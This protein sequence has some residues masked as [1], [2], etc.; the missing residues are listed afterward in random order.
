MVDGLIYM[1]YDA[2]GNESKPFISIECKNF[3]AV[4][5][6]SELKKVFKRIKG[7]IQCALVF[8]SS[9]KE[10][11]F[12]RTSLGNL[13]KE[14]F[15]QDHQADSVSVMEWDSKI[16]ADPKLLKVG[17]EIFKAETKTSLLVV[18]ISVGFVDAACIERKNER[19]TPS[20]A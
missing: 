17:G 18:I 10:N 7:G 16:E 6:T 4:V 3:A 5:D 20:L 8:V 1:Q 9:L 19:K 13:K 2:A 12:V 14:C 11:I 15:S